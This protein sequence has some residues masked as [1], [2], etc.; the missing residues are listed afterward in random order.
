MN[1]L[2][3]ALL[4]LGAGAVIAGMSVS[5]V[6]A[7]RGS[8]I[9]NLAIGGYSMVA[10]YAFWGLKRGFFNITLSTIPAF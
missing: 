3:F 4:G 2:L 1:T 7:Y 6:V 8:G 5:V 9:I 10:A